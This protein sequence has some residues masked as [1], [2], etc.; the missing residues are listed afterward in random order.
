MYQTRIF[1]GVNHNV[2][3]YENPENFTRN[4]KNQYFLTTP[5]A[6]PDRVI[7]QMQPLSVKTDLIPT[8][9]TTTPGLFLPEAVGAQIESIPDYSNYDVIVVSNIYANIARQ[10]AGTNPEYLDRLYTPV[11][12]YEN[13]PQ[14]CHDT[15]MVG[16]VGFRKVWYPM[17]PQG[18]VLEYRA[19][20]L[21]SLASAQICLD[22]YA[23]QRAYCDTYTASWLAE[24]KNWLSTKAVHSQSTLFA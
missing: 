21:P 7:R 22:I 20:R 16:S 18:Y 3:L 1:N 17:H 15:R 11:P 6:R 24:L 13:D 14:F 2:N 23:A 4:R 5:I 12:L 19:G 8:Q 9:V 10:L